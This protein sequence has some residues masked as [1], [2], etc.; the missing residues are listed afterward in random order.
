MR[1]KSC[2]PNT[3]TDTQTRAPNHLLYTIKTF[4]WTTLAERWRQHETETSAL[5]PM[6]N[7]QS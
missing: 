6:V 7:W 5:W 1:F 4:M 3:Q 2:C